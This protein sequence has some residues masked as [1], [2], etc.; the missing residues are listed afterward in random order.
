MS[1]SARF[2]PADPEA[3]VGHA[4]GVDH[5]GQFE[6]GVLGEVSEQRSSRAQEHRDQVD[7]EL[8]EHARAQA[9]L[10]QVGA[11]DQHVR[12]ACGPLGL[13]HRALDPVCHVVDQVRRRRGRLS[14]GG[15]EDRDAVVIAVPAAGD[16]ER[17]AADEHR[18]RRHRLVED[19]TARPRRPQA[20]DPVASV[21]EPVV[22]P[23]AAAAEALG[24]IVAGSGD[25]PV[26]RH[27]HVEDGAGHRSPLER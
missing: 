24:G 23:L 13:A 11:V 10:R 8:V 14:P 17:T 15:H 5:A 16:V 12:V 2:R 3:Q 21:A 19:L 25:E 20:G 4:G 6:L 1:L 7:L 18:S 9:R 22:K 27:R 26:E